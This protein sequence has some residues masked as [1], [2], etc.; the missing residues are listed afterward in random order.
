MIKERLDQP[1]CVAALFAVLC[2]AF[3]A[4]VNI[5]QPIAAPV[6]WTLLAVSVSKVVKRL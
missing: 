5:N 1:L 3:Q 6:M 4:A 2:Y